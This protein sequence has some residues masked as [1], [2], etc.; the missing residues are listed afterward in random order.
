MCGAFSDIYNTHSRLHEYHLLLGRD[1]REMDK[2]ARKSAHA[3]GIAGGGPKI[4]PAGPLGLPL[5]MAHV[6]G[7]LSLSLTNGPVTP[8]CVGRDSGG[9][10]VRS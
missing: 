8:V 3:K 5:H 1:A 9:C 6:K 4:C 10:T 7:P 2:M